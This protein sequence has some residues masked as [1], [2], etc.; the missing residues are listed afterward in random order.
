[1]SFIFALRK[2]QLTEE[3]NVYPILVLC[4]LEESLI[5]LIPYFY[6]VVFLLTFLI[7]T[8]GHIAHVKVFD[9]L[10]FDE[11]E[12]HPETAS[13]I[14]LRWHP[15]INQLVIGLSNG[16]TKVLYDEKQSRNGALLCAG[17]TKVCVAQ[18]CTIKVD[19]DMNASYCNL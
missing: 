6:T 14:R 2:E 12:S 18:R 10:T 4:Y 17:K 3:V 7:I 1:M 13:V 11:V 9:T 5:S 16:L 8:G 15:K 19:A